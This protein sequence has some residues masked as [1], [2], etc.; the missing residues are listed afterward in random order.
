MDVDKTFPLKK[1]VV[2]MPGPGDYNPSKDRRKVTTR[3]DVMFSDTARFMEKN[4]TT[5]TP[6]PGAYHAAPGHDSLL[7]PTYNVMLKND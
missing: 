7:I 3:K 6:G 5:P 4:T 1:Q 2:Y